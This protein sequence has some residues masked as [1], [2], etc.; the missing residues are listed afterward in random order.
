MTF[1]IL[2]PDVYD[3]ENPH[4][5]LPAPQA[6]RRLRLAILLSHPVQYFAPLFRELARR[7]E[8]HL[9]VIYC[10]LGGA[11]EQFDQEFT[12]TIQWDVPLLEGY[13]YKLVRSWW[14]ARTQGPLAYFAPGVLREITAARYDAVVVFGW[15][16]LT[17]WLAFL[18]ARLASIPWMLYGDTNFLYECEKRGPKRW[19]RNALLTALFRRTSAFL[20]SSSMNRRFYESHRA[21]R[22]KQFE[23]PFTADADFFRRG[24]NASRA[25]RNEIRSRH[26]IPCEALLLM[27][28]GKLVPRKR[29]H[30]LL[31]VLETL[32]SEFPKLA[33][34]FVGDGPLR[35][36]LEL[37]IASRR[38]D[39]AY[40][41]G[42][43]NQSDLPG[44]YA[45]ADVLVLPSSHEAIGVVAH[46]A[47][48]CGLPVIVSDRTGCWGPRDPVRDG[49][50]GLV[51]RCA[52]LTA[53]TQAVRTLARHPE[54]RERMANRSRRIT[55]ELTAT[56]CAEAVG[57]AVRFVCTGREEPSA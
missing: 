13:R 44:L 46:E 39:R 3:T 40:L 20:I 27:F 6:A 48:A 12:R 57:E 16:N 29:P 28:V 31:A 56:R 33:V 38:L 15:A 54:L 51:Y 7:S 41:L 25:R 34:A 43:K 22:A 17:C 10:S 30:D 47:A 36:V 18:R 4:G 26:G 21:P 1:S 5:V 50:N 2:R 42:F 53:L 52:D 9:T 14:P 24:A 23:A 37:D 49:E 11:R 8:I 32:G 45:M 19:L 35:E 55:D